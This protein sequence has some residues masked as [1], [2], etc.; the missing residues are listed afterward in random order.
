MALPKAK[1]LQ[2]VQ[3][4]RYYTLNLLEAAVMSGNRVGIHTVKT[5]DLTNKSGEVY[6]YDEPI[7]TYVIFDERPKV[8]LLKTL[9]WYREDTSELPIL[10]YIPTHLLYKK[11]IVEDNEVEEYVENY[12]T[13]IGAE[14]KELVNLGE[15]ENYKLKPLKI[16]RGTKI[17][18]EYDFLPESKANTFYVVNSK[19]D[20][21][22]LNYVV[23]LMPYKHGSESVAIDG[24]MHYIN[25]DSELY[26]M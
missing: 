1:I 18:I 2:T 11:E 12:T 7:Y 22:S 21:V 23:Q 19:I 14:M 4:K 6:T 9:G 5:S 26:G 24:N 16:I 25:F 15:S 3:E 17:D 20:T 8:H 10:A 13:L